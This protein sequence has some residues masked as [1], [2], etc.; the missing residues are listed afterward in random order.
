MRFGKHLTCAFRAINIWTGLITEQQFAVL[1]T[2]VYVGH[3]GTTFTVS[4]VICESKGPPKWTGHG[5]GIL[6]KKRVEQR[7][8]G[9]QAAQSRK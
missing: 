6:S 2:S 7:V 1:G 9:Y 4:P 8:A 3:W 5:S